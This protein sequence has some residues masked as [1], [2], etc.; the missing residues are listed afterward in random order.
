MNITTK[1][2]L[3]DTVVPIGRRIETISDPC[4]TCEGTGM[5][6]LV[7][8]GSVP[9]TVKECWY[10]RINRQQT[11]PWAVR[12][13]LTS[14]VGI[15]R[16]EHEAASPPEVRYMIFSTGVGSGTVWK[17][18]DLFA[19]DDEA[20]AECDRRNGVAATVPV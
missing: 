17:E 13:D 2:S 15:V 5:L 8:G 3:G 1:F 4:P 16:G 20:Q 6:A 7:K 11:H 14:T 9:C 18:E 12:A 10:G 19:T